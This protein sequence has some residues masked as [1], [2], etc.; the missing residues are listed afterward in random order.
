MG[1][2]ALVTGAHSVTLLAT[3]PP[4]EG[5]MS[6]QPQPPKKQSSEKPKPDYE[7]PTV[8]EIET[9][10]LSTAPGVGPGPPPGVL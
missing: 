7:P 8:E 2:D 1:G 4:Q 6:E 10:T 5:T 3:K 9:E